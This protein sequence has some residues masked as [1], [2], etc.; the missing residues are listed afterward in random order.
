VCTDIK[1]TRIKREKERE[2]GKYLFCTKSVCVFGYEIVCYYVALGMN[3]R[4]QYRERQE[5]ENIL[6]E[7]LSSAYMKALDCAWLPMEFFKFSAFR[8]SVNSIN[9]FEL[10]AKERY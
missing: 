9:F 2:N 4:R 8:F 10:D 6:I 1:C 7:Q 5:C 3:E